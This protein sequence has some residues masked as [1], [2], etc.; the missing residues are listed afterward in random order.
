M[1]EDFL[2]SKEAQ[3]SQLSAQIF[4]IQLIVQPL[5][6]SLLYKNSSNFNNVHIIV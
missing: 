4:K 6:P 3:Y 1:K 5:Y 2:D